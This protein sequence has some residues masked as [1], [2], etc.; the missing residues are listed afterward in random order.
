MYIDAE[1]NFFRGNKVLRFLNG[2]LI[3]N[4]RKVEL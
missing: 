1:N 4:L 3:Y 2:L